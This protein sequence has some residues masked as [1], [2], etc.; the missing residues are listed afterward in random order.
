[1]GDLVHLF[2]ELLDL[3]L[4]EVF[5]LIGQLL[6]LLGE[7]GAAVAKLLAA[8]LESL[9]ELFSVGED[10]CELLGGDAGL[11]GALVDDIRVVAGSSAIPGKDLLI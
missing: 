2:E 5:N 4:D 11:I 10:D 9:L 8:V 3:L 7:L 6:N 1:V